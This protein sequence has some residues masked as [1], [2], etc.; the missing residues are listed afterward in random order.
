MS[1]ALTANDLPEVALFG[2][3]INGLL[4]IIKNLRGLNI[5]LPDILKLVDFVGKATTE[6]TT[7]GKVMAALEAM[8]M[9]AAATGN[10]TDDKIVATIGTIL[11]GPALDVLCNVIDS[12]LG[13]RTLAMDTVESEVTALA[14]DWNAFRQIAEMI[15]AIIRSRQQK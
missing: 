9:V 1:N 5:G 6:E 13:N 10:T 2:G 12:Y 3:R 11:S 7:K 15:L 8:K 14:I 4:E